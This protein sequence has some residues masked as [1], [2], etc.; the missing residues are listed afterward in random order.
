MTDQIREWSLLAAGSRDTTVTVSAAFLRFV[1]A[2]VSRA[3]MARGFYS[4][5][6]SSRDE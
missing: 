3:P 1:G 5:T 4:I 6:S 2:C